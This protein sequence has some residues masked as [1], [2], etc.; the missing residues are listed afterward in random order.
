MKN[1]PNKY[2]IVWKKIPDFWPDFWERYFLDRILG[3]FGG[4]LEVIFGGCLGTFY[5]VFNTVL[6]VFLENF[7]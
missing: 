5:M 4:T 3:D 1:L 6:E 7:L 2:S